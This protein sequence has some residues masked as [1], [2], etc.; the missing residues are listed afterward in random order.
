MKKKKKKKKKLKRKSK[1]LL[2]S[3]QRKTSKKIK[4]LLWKS[5]I[6][7]KNWKEKYA[8]INKKRRKEYIKNYYY[9]R[10][11]LFEWFD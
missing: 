11:N 9:K 7:R 6:R 3:Q 2:P 8:N 5:F 4:R 1:K 10:K